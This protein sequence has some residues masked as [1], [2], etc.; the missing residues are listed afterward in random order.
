M[1]SYGIKQVI[2]RLQSQSEAV[3][4]RMILNTY[5]WEHMHIQHTWNLEA[6]GGRVDREDALNKF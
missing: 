6:H 1:N 4:A 3:T 2:S 5:P